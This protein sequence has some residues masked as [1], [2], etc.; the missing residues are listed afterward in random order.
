M[1]L[2][3][4]EGRLSGRKEPPPW[5]AHLLVLSLWLSLSNKV[6]TAASLLLLLYVLYIGNGCQW[7]FGHQRTN[8]NR[9]YTTVQ[10]S[11]APFT[12]LSTAPTTTTTHTTTIITFSGSTAEG[13][14]YHSFSAHYYCRILSNI[15]YGKRAGNCGRR[16]CAFQINLFIV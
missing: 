6:R 13:I 1:R 9:L 4:Q 15:L 16:F 7:K 5:R 10:F 8:R 2:G 3:V 14:K 12:K 11:P